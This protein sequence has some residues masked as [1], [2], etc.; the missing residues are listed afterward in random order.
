MKLFVTVAAFAIG[1]GCIA[2][3]TVP[4]SAQ[5]SD[6]VQN[7]NIAIDYMEP[8]NPIYTYGLRPDD[9][10]HLKAFKAIDARY[11]R[12]K[13]I[14]ERLQKRRLLEE[15][16]QF[17]APLRLPLK[18]RLI[19][20]ECETANAFFNFVDMSITMCYELIAEIEN[21]APKTRTPEGITRQEA[22]VGEVVGTMLHEAGHMISRLFL[23][24]VLGREEDTADQIAA[25]VMLQFGKDVARTLIRGEV[26]GWNWRARNYLTAYWGVHSTNLQRQHTYLCIAYGGDPA[27]FQD[28]VNNG[29]LPKTRAANCAKDYKQVELAFNKTIL[30]HLDL[31][32]VKKVRQRKWIKPDDLN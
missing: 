32:L 23:L 24:P 26:H 31:E 11:Q 30:P 13:A 21:R 7:P 28:L 27:T 14:K 4:A 29:W 5:G 2:D 25:F 12:Y 16:S 17:L 20:K 9:P 1:I 19:T 3:P 10:E 6:Y 22:I 18:I 8:L 15:F